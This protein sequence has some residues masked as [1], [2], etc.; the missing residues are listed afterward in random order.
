MN[1]FCTLNLVASIPGDSDGKE[2]ACTV[3]DLGSFPG[4]GRSPGAGN[5][6]QFQYYC[7]ENPMD[8]GTWQAIVHE[9]TKSQT[10]LS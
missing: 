10:G 7:L 8:G 4:S 6:N 5:G 2:S 3:G 1:T 9:V